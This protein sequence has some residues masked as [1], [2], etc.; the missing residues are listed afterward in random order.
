MRTLNR[1][2]EITL[3]LVVFNVIFFF[4]EILKLGTDFVMGGSNVGFLSVV[5]LNA[6][7]PLYTFITSMFLHGSVIHL[8][9]NMGALLSIG[10]MIRRGF[11]LFFYVIGYFASGI[12]A[13]ILSV[14]VMPDTT[15]VGASG[16][17]FGLFGMYIAYALFEGGF[18]HFYNAAISVGLSLVSG[19]MIPQVNIW[20]HLGGA[21][22]GFVLGLVFMLIIKGG[23]KMQQGFRNRNNPQRRRSDGEPEEE[24]QRFYY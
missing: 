20:A 11:G 6:S 10:L 3:G 18:N 22:I 14:M 24:E 17:I 9:M 21:V 2:D 16:A 8:I 7:T 15:T 13:N 12:G 4:Y 19:L 1:Q 5:A 23:Q